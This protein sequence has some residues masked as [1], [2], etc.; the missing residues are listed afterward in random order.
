MILQRWY[1]LCFM[2]TSDSGGGL[3]QRLDRDTQR[4]AYKCSMIVRN[5]QEMDVFKVRLKHIFSRHQYFVFIFVAGPC[6]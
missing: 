2:F 4:C 6:D 3:L 5:G 1:A